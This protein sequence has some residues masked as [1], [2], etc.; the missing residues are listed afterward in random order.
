MAHNILLSS[1]GR[2]GELVRILQS[3]LRD[4]DP[5]GR[6]F[7]ADMSPLSSAGMLGDGHHLVPPARD[8]SFV[9]TLLELCARLE[10]THV[11]PTID[12]ELP[13][14]ASRLEDFAAAGV[15]A[16]VSAPAAISIARDK[17][18]TNRFLTEHGLPVAR[19]VELDAAGEL[20]P[21]LIAK[22]AGGSSSIGLR[23]AS[24]A[25]ELRELDRRLDYVVEEVAPGVEYTVDCLVGRDGHCW[26]AVPR[27]RI[28][29]RAGEVSKGWIHRNPPVEEV[30]RQVVQ[31]LPGAFG[32]L[33]VQVMSDDDTGRLA[34]IEINAR[35]GG[36]FPLTYQ[37]GADFPGWLLRHLAGAQAEPPGWRDGV[38]MLR[39]DQGVYVEA[40]DLGLEL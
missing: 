26:A 23:R 5:A 9:P 36:G 2:R 4:F 34:V 14:F 29:V 18:L 28:E 1:S 11:I 39:Y 30:A 37:A 20:T 21:P 6:V 13:V 38:V 12:T 3:S 16:W 25:R 15:N 33:N 40:A 27:R 35:F 8:P 31:S 22:P 24:S 32:V 19:Q 10:I 17:R 7:T